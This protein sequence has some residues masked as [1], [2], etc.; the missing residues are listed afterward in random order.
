[1]IALFQM[2]FHVVPVAGTRLET[3]AAH[4]AFERF[5]FDVR[6]HVRC[7]QAGCFI[8]LVANRAYVRS[9]STVC[10]CAK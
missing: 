7:S 10:T 4:F 8:R 3:F 2:S 1:M 6:I 5:P 9:F